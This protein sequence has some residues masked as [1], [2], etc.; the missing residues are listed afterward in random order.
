M[1]IIYFLIGCSILMALVFLAAF[2]WSVKNGQ[3][4]DMHTPA[5]RML[6]ED[7]KPTEDDV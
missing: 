1:N 3:H 6:F 4:D 2:I 7:D 5:I